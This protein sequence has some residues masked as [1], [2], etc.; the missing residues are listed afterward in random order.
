MDPAPL[1]IDIPFPAVI[2]LSIGSNPVAPI[3]KDPSV[4]GYP[5]AFVIVTEPVLF[6]TLIP[7]PATM[8]FIPVFE[9][10][11]DPGPFV[12]EIPSPAVRLAV[13]GSPSSRP[14]SSLP[15]PFK[16]SAVILS[17]MTPSS[18]SGWR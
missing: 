12:I 9:T 17:A 6:S 7:A 10:V 5:D 18:S 13:S 14:I 11:T 2:V 8:S 4:V 16:A 1:V 3:S 15:L